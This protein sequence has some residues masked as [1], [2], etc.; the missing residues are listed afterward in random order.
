MTNK[1]YNAIMNS[2]LKQREEVSKSRE[3]AQ[4]LL[5]NLGIYHLL[6][7]ID[8]NER[9]TRVEANAIREEITPLLQSAD[10]ET[11]K[12]IHVLLKKKNNEQ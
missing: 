6:V 11:L 7:P 12:E 1:K 4:K 5:K 9:K 3:A 8:E 10:I 2:L